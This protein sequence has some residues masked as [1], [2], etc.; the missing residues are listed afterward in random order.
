MERAL[1]IINPISGT[2]GKQ[3]VAEHIES[4]LAEL[5]FNVEIKF[6]TGTGHATEL[7]RE[8]ATNGFHSVVAIGGDGTV[9]ETASG[10]CNTDVALGI[11]PAGSGNGLAR[12]LNIPM[13]IDR[14]IDVITQRNIVDCDYGEVNHRP[15]FCTFGVGFDAA[16]SHRFA[17][18]NRR[19]KMMYIKSAIDEYLTYKPQ[20]YT[21]SANGKVLTEKAFLI[22]VCNA[23]QYGNNA[24]I[25]PT[26]SI[27]DGLL[28]FT[29]VH[30]G[31]PA[32]AAAFGLD[33]MTG[34]IN[35]NVMIHTFK[36]Q[37]AVITRNS[38]GPVHIDGEPLVMDRAIYIQ[39][40]HG[41]VKLY[42]SPKSADFKPIVTPIKNMF[43][44][45][46]SDINKL[47][48]PV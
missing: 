1:L 30:A 33:L 15:F 22:A 31:T 40:N 9:N 25:A 4:R 34:Y 18:Q 2:G 26:A 6:T 47:F 5:G 28:D 39:C 38:D 20:E 36:A 8:A 41:G 19:G 10:L 21:I 12:H 24:Y 23:S 37:A 46:V 32:D 42:A 11:I 27:T 13:D 7:A 35:K 44:D 45:F 17:Q 3:G 43:N 29:I 48:K 16:V 14:A